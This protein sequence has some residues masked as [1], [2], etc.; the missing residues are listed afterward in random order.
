[1]RWRLVNAHEVIVF[2]IA[3]GC[4]TIEIDLTDKTLKV[5]TGIHSVAEMFTRH[6]GFAELAQNG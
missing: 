1:M 2:G 5:G 6:D 4:V 3:V